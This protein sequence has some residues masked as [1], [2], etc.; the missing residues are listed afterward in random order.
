MKNQKRAAFGFAVLFEIAWHFQWGMEGG[1]WIYRHG[2]PASDLGWIQEF[3]RQLFSAV[4]RSWEY[5][6]PPR[7]NCRRK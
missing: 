6:Y 4:V 5:I 2:P 1:N 3:G 7:R